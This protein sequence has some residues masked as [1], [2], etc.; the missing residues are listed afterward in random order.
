MPTLYEEYIEAGIVPIPNIIQNHRHIPS[1]SLQ[2]RRGKQ[3]NRT[4]VFMRYV[5]AIVP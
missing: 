2:G 5:K 1:F 4:L 3:Q